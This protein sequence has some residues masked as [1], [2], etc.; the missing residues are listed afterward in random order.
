MMAAKPNE[1][2]NSSP[3][4]PLPAMPVVVDTSKN[5]VDT[6][7]LKREQLDAAEVKVNAANAAIKT[8]RKG[9]QAGLDEY[10]VVKVG[11]L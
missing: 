5:T 8:P 6:S 3:L 1:S 2:P 7:R 10:Y 11:G 4:K 9:Q